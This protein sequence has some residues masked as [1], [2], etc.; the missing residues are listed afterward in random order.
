[1]ALSRPSRNELWRI[2]LDAYPGI[3]A[4]TLVLRLVGRNIE[5]HST[6]GSNRPEKYMEVVVA[7]DAGGWVDDLMGGVFDHQEGNEDIRARLS[8]LTQQI[9]AERNAPVRKVSLFDHAYSDEADDKLASAL[10]RTVR[11]GQPDAEVRV[12]ADRLTDIS[13]AVCSVEWSREH[14]GTGLL[15]GPRTL[16]T[17]FHV[18]E[19]M[20]G[21]PVSDLTA[22]FGFERG[23]GA[24][25]RDGKRT[26]FAD[27]WLIHARPPD[28]ADDV[29][30]PAGPPAA[31]H[32]DYAV[33]R[34]TAAPDGVQPVTP[35]PASPGVQG[36][37]IVLIQHPAGAPKKISFGRI[38]ALTGE[39]RRL[40]YDANTKPGSSGSPVL[41]HTGQLIALHHA[42]DPNFD[43]MAQY[44]QAVPIS[45]ILADMTANQVE[46]I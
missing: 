28:P 7:A 33:V 34:L 8:A 19:P 27:S 43:R 24:I 40:R 11:E 29:G 30:G 1:M 20:Q 21:Q 39:G 44:N 32:L 3:S 4:L 2:L 26:A 45:L 25:I 36:N 18:I 16:I 9:E 6:P 5:D 13:H 22:R 14:Q 15:I 17:N 46:V 42:G 41:D 35:M 23:E 38:T 37:D 12:F 31:A 10:Q